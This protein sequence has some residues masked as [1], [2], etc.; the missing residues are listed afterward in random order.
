MDLPP[1]PDI[2]EFGLINSPLP[3]LS[4]L[5]PQADA[6]KDAEVAVVIGSELTRGGFHLEKC[7]TVSGYQALR[8]LLS[9]P[10][11]P[12]R[13][14]HLLAVFAGLQ[15]GDGEDGRIRIFSNNSDPSQQNL[16]LH[17]DKNTIDDFTDMLHEHH[18]TIRDHYMHVAELLDWTPEDDAED[19]ED[20][21]EGEEEAE[22][23]AP[24]KRSPRRPPPHAMVP[25]DDLFRLPAFGPVS[26][27]PESYQPI[28]RSV[29]LYPLSRH[30]RY[31]KLGKPANGPLENRQLLSNVSLHGINV[32]RN[33]LHATGPFCGYPV[34]STNDRIE[35]PDI[36]FNNAHANT[37][38]LNELGLFIWSR[39]IPLLAE[40]DASKRKRKSSDRRQQFIKFEF[41][42]ATRPVM[43]RYLRGEE[44]TGVEW[45]PKYLDAFNT[46]VSSLSRKESHATRLS[47]GKN[48]VVFCQ[49]EQLVT[50]YDPKD[51]QE[52][53]T[54]EG[55]RLGLFR[56]NSIVP[57][58]YTTLSTPACNTP[59]G[60]RLFNAE[61]DK[62]ELS[63]SGSEVEY[64]PNRSV[65]PSKRPHGF[66][67]YVPSKRPHVP[68]AHDVASLF[69]PSD[70]E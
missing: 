48:Y 6:A 35:I 29:P 1:L 15:P 27:L 31:V 54:L 41:A 51:Y 68:T 58:F 26:G 2:A 49:P 45:T 23:E 12:P 42:V 30:Y 64:N 43:E 50:E 69:E 3:S 19:D 37:G 10:G 28:R 52:L 25:A 61:R 44:D 21:S 62:E 53:L 47:F 5:F 16:T 18:A 33:R 32:V 40:K 66:P 56:F 11:S 59:T 22:E 57:W 63:A 20:E 60:E 39:V 14:I 8:F 46:F 13:F 70:G 65:V 55:R 38:R 17:P 7:I 34:R 24:P 36:N 67:A 9:L 4:D